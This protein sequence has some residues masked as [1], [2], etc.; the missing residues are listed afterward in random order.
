MT[1]EGAS[2][3]TGERTDPEE[4]ARIRDD[5]QATFRRV[6]FAIGRNHPEQALRMLQPL[7]GQLDEIA[8]GP[9][10]GGRTFDFSNP[11]EAYLYFALNPDTPLQEVRGSVAPYV[12]AYG[13]HA[14]LLYQL[15]RFGEAAAAVDRALRW[16]P[17]DGSLYLERA[18]AHE[19]AGQM[20]AVEGDIESAYPLI[21][22]PVDL[23]RYHAFRADV[24][25]ARGKYDLAAAHYAVYEDFDP[26][27]TFAEPRE[28]LRELGHRTGHGHAYAKLTSEE[29]VRRLSR[30]GE[31]YGPSELAVS[32]LQ[33]ILQDGV[34]SGDFSAARNA[35]QSLWSL[36]HF[37]GWKTMLQKFDRLAE[38]E[39]NAAHAVADERKEGEGKDD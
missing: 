39:A 38:A 16:C 12:D 33:Q 13:T 21:T 22:R 30:A 11:E 4:V 14:A 15:G 8:E 6:R 29:A 34:E 19:A 26:N 17:T 2:E 1:E 28:E 27:D 24:L 25:V 31:K 36:T 3:G 23:A 20:D 9:D 5:A 35:T 37:D 18:M 32:V 7:L 10:A